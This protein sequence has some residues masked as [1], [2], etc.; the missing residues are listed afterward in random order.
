MGIGWIPSAYTGA[1]VKCVIRYGA[2]EL[3]EVQDVEY[4]VDKN[5]RAGGA[6]LGFPRNRYHKTGVPEG[7]FKISKNYLNIGEQADLFA[8][9][10]AGTTE[11][12][13]EALT[14]GASTYTPTYHIVSV[15]YVMLDDGTVLN[16]GTDYLIDYVNNAIEFLSAL[17][18]DGDV[19][20]ITNDATLLADD[21]M[22]GVMHPFV[23]DV[24]WR[25]RDSGTVL[26]RL[27]GCMVY[28]HS[29]SSGSDE[30]AFTEDIE[31]Q[32]LALESRGVGDGILANGSTGGE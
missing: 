2:Y 13:V 11:I 1:E 29:M 27:R 9:L 25:E 19:A 20:Y 6:G 24:E 7:E 16:E 17:T 22:D 31:G 23:F 4:S 3:I 18:D 10:I 14:V 28:T 26:K 12:Q 30:E 5:A 15:L 8:Q 32:F 21:A